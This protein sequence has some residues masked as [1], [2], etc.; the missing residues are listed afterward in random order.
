MCC[1]TSL[2]RDIQHL[3]AQFNR[4]ENVFLVALQSHRETYRETLL[5]VVEVGVCMVNCKQSIIS[6][7]SCGYCLHFKSDN[8]TKIVLLLVGN[9]NVYVISMIIFYLSCYNTKLKFC[10]KG[11]M[12]FRSNFA[13]SINT[14][15]TSVLLWHWCIVNKVEKSTYEDHELCYNSILRQ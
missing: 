10:D 7:L 8:H 1:C 2:S 6:W 13:V 11:R 12:Y 9:D 14:S 15:I 3:Q 5:L 4:E